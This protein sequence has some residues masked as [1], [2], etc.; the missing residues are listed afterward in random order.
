MVRVSGEVRELTQAEV[1]E[2]AAGNPLF[3]VAVYDINKYPETVVFVLHRFHGEYY[4]Y[5]FNMVHRD[6]KILR[7]RF[8]FGGDSFVPAGLSNR[9]GP[10]H[11]MRGVCRGVRAQG[12]IPDR[13]RCSL[14]YPSASAATSAALLPCL[15]CWS[16]PVKGLLV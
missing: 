4:D 16:R 2:K 12:D 15:P 5:D 10:L 13:R 8:A 6:H 7:E 9:S 3:N 14:P 11:C 1:D